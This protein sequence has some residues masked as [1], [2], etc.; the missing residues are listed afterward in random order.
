MCSI[1]DLPAE[2]SHTFVIG[3]G[4]VLQGMNFSHIDT[5]VQFMDSTTSNVRQV[6]AFVCGD[7]ETPLTEN[8][9]GID[10]PI[11]DCRV[12][13]HLRF[14]V[15]VDMIPGQY[16]LQVLVPNPDLVG[17][18]ADPLNSDSV[19]VMIDLPST[20]RFQISTKL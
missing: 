9:N 2:Q 3:Q 4:V 12:H 15:P 10:V 7:A 5:K 14:T 16:F 8:I 18:W 11:I 20:A 6:D 13:D 19:T 1:N 17:G